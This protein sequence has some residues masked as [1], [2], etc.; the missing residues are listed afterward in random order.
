MFS[1]HL[2]LIGMPGSG[3]SSLGRRAARETGLPFVD[4]DEMIS[5][6]SGMSISDIF[7]RYGEESFR[8]AETGTLAELS[9]LQPALVSTGGGI[10]L[11]EE[12]R[13]IMRC[14]GAIA[15]LDRTP[16]QIMEHLKTEDRPLLQNG[17]EE[18]LLK[19]YEERYP[20]Y[21]SAADFVIRNDG[22][23]MQ[24]LRRLVSLL[25]DRL[26]A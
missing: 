26:G 14:W 25:K 9:R 22:E 17:G 6:I 18:A 1:R 13:R 5:D 12:N 4:T 7:A 11:R 3:K 10:I 23:Y 20:I 15:F 8:K 16:E 19:L 2:F 24:T 21:R